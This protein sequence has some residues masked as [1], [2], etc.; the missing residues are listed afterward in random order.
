VGLVRDGI[1]RLRAGLWIAVA[2]GVVAALSP[3]VV[4]PVLPRAAMARHLAAGQ[5]DASGHPARPGARASAGQSRALAAATAET[6]RRYAAVLSDIGKR[7][8]SASGSAVAEAAAAREQS[9]QTEVIAA[10]RA[11]VYLP[12]QGSSPISAVRV[13]KLSDESGGPLVRALGT[14][15]PAD[16]LVVAPSTLPAAVLSAIRKLPGV[17][18]ANLLDAAR[19]KV[20]G[21]DVAMLGVN[22]STFREFAA[23]PTAKSTALWQNVADGGIAVSYLMGEQE[24]LL[25]GGTVQVAGA[26][27]EELPVGG[28]GTV[29]ISGVDAVVSDAVASS[30]G[31]PAGN[32]IVISAPH[33]RLSTLIRQ[34]R[35]VLP[36]GAA[37]APLV[38]QAPAHGLPVTQGSAGA[39]GVTPADGP[40]L[41]VAQT[42]A[43]L[44][45]ALSRVGFRYVWGGAGPTVF[46]CSGL[47]QW[48]MRQAGLV[49]PRV[50]VDQAQTGPRIPLSSL[51]PGDLL[52]YHTDP[53]APTYISHVA[54]Y[55][56]KGLML[57][58]PEPGED[59]Q[60]VPAIFGG[61]F[62]GA[63]EVYPRVAAAV[64][65]DPAG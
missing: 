57:Q 48:S 49:M 31:M 19:I 38:G 26:R 64:A 45:A 16:L 36:S 8:A 2:I 55:L 65:G 34:I 20:N 11:G 63:V 42:K 7:P 18:A 53:T 6:L 37:V 59:V 44:T 61:G 21:G 24:K 17:T 46:D 30:L 9:G 23:K 3:K 22:P 12:G 60:V 1:R 50:A 25:I 14:L 51:E 62:A 28:F 33:A 54:I 27:T 41:T 39:I 10:Q 29:G 32:A 35:L 43:F 15:H 40:G 47:V 58:A 5:V 13:G 4:T 52:F 56:G